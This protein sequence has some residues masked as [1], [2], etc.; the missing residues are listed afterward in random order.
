MGVVLGAILK[1]SRFFSSPRERG[2]QQ[3]ATFWCLSIV[4]VLFSE[5]GWRIT[6]GI[7]TTHRLSPDQLPHAGSQQV[8]KRTK[9]GGVK[10][11]LIELSYLLQSNLICDHVG[12][13]PTKHGGRPECRILCRCL[14]HG[15]ESEHNC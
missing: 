15:H 3:G 9:C 14:L 1:I 6:L 11:D 10:I 2:D 13:S 4:C 7:N 12:V 5:N 8:S